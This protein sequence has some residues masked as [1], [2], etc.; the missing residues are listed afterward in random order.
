M[1]FNNFGT[2]LMV[3]IWTIALN[4]ALY[5]IHV[6]F[7][8]KSLANHL[9]NDIL[10]CPFVH[11]MIYNICMSN[12]FSHSLFSFFRFKG[13]SSTLKLSREKSVTNKTLLTN[14]H[15]PQV[16]MPT[17]TA[18]MDNG[19]PENAFGKSP[20]SAYYYIYGIVQNL[21]ISMDFSI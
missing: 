11:R 14:E 10:T 6:P 17:M 19:S 3:N 21:Q 8:W 18:E 15:L 9:C 1:I 4:V 16:L 7:F 12:L 5:V 13:Q 20:T 2:L